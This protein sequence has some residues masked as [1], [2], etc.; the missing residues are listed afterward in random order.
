[1]V[2]SRSQANL[3][4]REYPLEA[5]LFHSKG[6]FGLKR[7]S[8]IILSLVGLILLL[9]LFLVLIILIKVTSPN[10]PAFFIQ[11]RV[12]KGGK[13]LRM[14]KFRSMHVDAEKRLAELLH[15]NEVEGA[16]FKLK[17]DPRVTKIGA[18][19]R[20]F[21]IDELPQLIN[22]LKGEMSL[23][24]PRPP[25]PRETEMYTEYDKQRLLI[26]PGCTGLWQVSGRSNLSFN[27]MVELDLEYIRNIS[28]KN[29]IKIFIKTFRVILEGDAC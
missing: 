24:G 12:G 10:G 23:I 14:F 22:V 16:M 13:E 4:V 27:E 11:T 3:R 21:S 20:K 26:T 25:L 2:N 28:L 19:M 18:F 8:D 1:M 29:D 6:Y 5:A 15:L 7:F 17:S 9:P